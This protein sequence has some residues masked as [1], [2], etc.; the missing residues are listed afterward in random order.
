M[1]CQ[2]AKSHGAGGPGTPPA[3]PEP[4]LAIERSPRSREFSGTGTDRA[5]PV[6]EKFRQ[7]D[8]TRGL[9]RNG[10]FGLRGAPP[11][12]ELPG[13]TQAQTIAP[14]NAPIKFS[15]TSEELVNNPI[16]GANQ[17]RKNQAQGNGAADER[18]CHSPGFLLSRCSPAKRGVGGLWRS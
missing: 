18:L 17:K 1:F 5:F 6:S 4:L 14:G 2:F 13:A 8:R 16:R 3:A 12:D 9:V 10:S 11:G 7:R 15:S